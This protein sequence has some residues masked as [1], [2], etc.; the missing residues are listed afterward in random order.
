MYPLVV[1]ITNELC[2]IWQGALLILHPEKLIT[3]Q[4]GALSDLKDQPHEVLVGNGHKLES[5]G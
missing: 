5:T 4:R 3:L 1:E 2:V